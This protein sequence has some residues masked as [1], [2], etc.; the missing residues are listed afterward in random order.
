MNWGLHMTVD[1][2]RS[3]SRERG[4]WR[5]GGLLRAGSA[6]LGG[7]LFLAACGGGTGTSSSSSAAT[8]TPTPVCQGT[9]AAPGYTNGIATVAGQAS[10]LSGAG[11]TFV[12]PMMSVWTSEFAKANT[13][14]VA[15]QAVGSGAGIAQLQAGTVDWGESDAFMTDADIAK[16]KGPVVQVPLVQAPVVVAY[17]LPGVK[18]GLKL[19][20]DTIGKIFAGLITTWNDPAIAALNPGVTLPTLPVAVAHR[21]DG[22]GTTAI[23]T[24]YLTK[25]SPS[26]VTA[27]GGATKSV[28]KTVAWPVGTGGKG[29]QGVSAAIGQTT[30]GVGY[31]ELN[32]AI[33]QGLTYADVKNKAGNFIEPCAKTAA[34]ATVGITDYP[35]DL[36][37]DVIDKSSNAQAYPITGLT[38][39]LIYQ[40]QTDQ[41]KAAAMVNFF[42]W[43]LTSGQDLAPAVF[44]TPLGADLQKLCIAQL[45]K[46]TVNGSP[47]AP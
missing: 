28:G 9:V 39:A 42:S 17:N 26:W 43:V 14:Q 47:I 29:N 32:Y 38:W 34:L 1:I 30:G 10:S 35:P 21:S 46:I 33:A 20:G 4:L 24:N 36:R 3:R 7:S 5:S 11:G 8:A 41:G 19:D 31:V 13:V 18:T 45:H 6:L 22:S 2:V 37:V 15:Y 44:Y 25:E 27:L 16:G 12:A 23:F 40:S